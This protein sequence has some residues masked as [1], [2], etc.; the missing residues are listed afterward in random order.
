MENRIYKNPPINEM[1]LS[2]HFQADP[3][4]GV[5]DFQQYLLKVEENFKDKQYIFPILERIGDMGKIPTEPEKIKFS[6]EDETKLLQFLRDRM[7][8]NWRAEKKQPIIYPKYDNIKPEFLKYWRILSDYIRNYKD[9]KLNIK[10]SE[11][12]YSNII[13]IGKNHFLKNDLDLHKAFNFISPYPEN[14]KN[15][16]PY[17]NLETPIDKDTLFFRLE[18][19]KDNKEN[20][21]AFLL[22]FSMRSNKPLEDIDINWYDKAHQ[23][24]NKFFKEV[25]TE[26]IKNFWKGE[27]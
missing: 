2:V 15:I 18:K 19:I 21:E 24:I 3:L 5:L 9:R 20:S 12:Y 13:Q 4:I 22:V 14:Y 17:I 27:I 1:Y 25:T 11:L 8:Y 16:I 7:V 6:S 10:M 23:N 26:E